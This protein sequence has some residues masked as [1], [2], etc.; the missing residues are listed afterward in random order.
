MTRLALRR[1]FLAL[2]TIVAAATLV[3]LLVHVVP[4]DPVDVM[5]GESAAPADREALRHTLGL[6]RPLLAQYGAFLLAG[7]LWKT[8]SVFVDALAR[9]LASSGIEF[10]M[11]R[12][13]TPP[14][15][16]AVRLAR[17]MA[18]GH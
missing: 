17:E 14:V 8:S 13:C 5:L 1:I 9:S 4:G 10:E 7:G 12:I 3:F 15:Y 6:D 18:I 16:G 2:P 11:E